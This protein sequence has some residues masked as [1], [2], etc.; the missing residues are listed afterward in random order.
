MHSVRG[1]GIGGGGEGSH[2]AKGVA[3]DAGDLDQSEDRVAGEAQ[4][5]LHANFGGV[6]DLAHVA[7]PE[8]GGGGGGHRDGGADFT[9]TADLGAADTGPGNHRAA[10]ETGRH[11]GV[12]DAFLGNVVVAMEV[13]E[14]A[15]KNAA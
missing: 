1:E 13:V 12:E 11:D 2:G 10:K 3:F 6:F 9:L 14:H 5:V 8:L 15:R 7:A 4:G